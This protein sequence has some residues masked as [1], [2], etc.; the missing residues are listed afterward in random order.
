MFFVNDI[1]NIVKVSVA[2]Y[3]P[4]DIEISLINSVNL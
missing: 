1:E 3:Q 2:G 4:E